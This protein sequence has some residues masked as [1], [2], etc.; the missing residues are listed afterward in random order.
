M[1][2][3]LKY[4]SQLMIWRYGPRIVAVTGSAGKTSAVEA[5]Y[6]VLTHCSG[7]KKCPK[8]RISKGIV[9]HSAFA[10]PLAILGEWSDEESLFALTRKLTL[11]K[12]IKKVI[13]GFKIIF[14]SLWKIFIIKD[15]D[16][17][18]ILVLEYGARH[19]KDMKYLLGIARPEVG[20]ITAI[21]KIP[22]HVEFWSSPDSLVKEKSKLIEQ[23]SSSGFAILNSDDDAVIR[24]KERTRAKIVTFGFNE[25]ADLRIISFDNRT[26]DGRPFGISFKM[27]YGGSV[28][29]V[30]IDNIFGKAEAYTAAVAASVGLVFDLNLVEISEALSKNYKSG[31]DAMKLQPGIKNTM[32]L[33]SSSNASPASVEEALYI[34]RDLP[35]ARKI[36]VLGDMLELG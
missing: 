1:K 26:D 17:P 28:V 6:A 5:I 12:K 29:P 15:S 32:I 2:K 30:I 33:N 18:G 16:Y 25:G 21:G 4:L 31:P 20:I 36:A 3:I 13:F 14:I 11:K 24:L 7:D 19:P 23:L 22:A 9:H 35:G 34:L 10:A 27:N 8:V